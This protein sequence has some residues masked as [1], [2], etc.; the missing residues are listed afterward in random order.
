[1][2]DVQIRHRRLAGSFWFSYLQNWFCDPR[3]ALLWRSGRKAVEWRSEESRCRAAAAVAL[4]PVRSAPWGS[5]LHPRAQRPLI[6]SRDP[7]C[8][9]GELNRETRPGEAQ[10]PPIRECRR[11]LPWQALITA[12]SCSLRA[13]PT[14]YCLTSC[15]LIESFLY[16]GGKFIVY[17]W[18]VSCA[19]VESFSVRR[20]TPSDRDLWLEHLE[21]YN[22]HTQRSGREGFIHTRALVGSTFYF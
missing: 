13:S 21:C 4:T 10:S 20:G 18:K 1:M 17:Q 3:D 16:T 7:D 5:W 6:R 11:R 15:A 14:V 8:P 22:Q 19:P 9:G 2:N 12:R